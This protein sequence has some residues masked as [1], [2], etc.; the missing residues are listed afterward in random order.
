MEHF[1]PSDDTRM[2]DQA[3]DDYLRLC[4]EI[5]LAMKQADTWPWPDSQIPEDLI[6]SND[7]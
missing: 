2:P 3:L 7:I 1:D 4:Q 5:Y 6:E